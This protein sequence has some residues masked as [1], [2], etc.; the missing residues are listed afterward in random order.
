MNQAPNP[1]RI[2]WS[3]KRITR[4]LWAFV[5]CVLAVTPAIAQQL[6]SSDPPG[7]KSA[8]SIAAPDPLPGN[9]S[10]TVLDTNNDIIP[11]A[12][13]V[14]KDPASDQNHAAVANDNGAFEF[15]GLKPGDSYQITVSADGFV[16]WTSPS[17]ILNPGQFVFLTS[18]L[19]IA[20]GTN[21][22]TVYAYPDQIAVEQLRIEEKQRVLGF[23]PN[24]YVTYDHNAAPL[25]A[26]LKFELALKTSTDPI[27]FLGAAALAGINQAGDRPNYVEGAKG[28]GQ[29]LGA[30][31]TSTFVNIMI[32]G[33][34]LPSLLH[35]DPRYFY[36]GTGTTKSRVLHAL[37]SPFICKGDNGRWQPNY[38]SIGGDLATGAISNIYYPASNRGPGL[39]FENTLISTG[40]RMVDGL[41]QEFILRRLTPGARKRSH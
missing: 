29:R 7:D 6:V 2:S 17:V 15:G 27:T 41:I 37:S 22:V 16:S 28:Y 8:P 39:V 21:S 18:A 14:L 19:K 1:A 31:Y 25:T 33:A 26:K 40:G 4:L 32:G 10:G 34:I 20:G 11:G 13:V 35:Q 36:Q 30:A 3:E 24:F 5:G 38:S 23:I 12:T 9:I